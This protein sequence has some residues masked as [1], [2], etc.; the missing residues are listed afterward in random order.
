MRRRCLPR[1][2]LAVMLA[3]VCGVQV[4]AQAAPQMDPAQYLQGIAQQ[5]QQALDSGEAVQILSTSRHLAGVALQVLGAVYAA[6]EQPGQAAEAYGRSLQAEESAE[7]R[8][9]LIRNDVQAERP[10]DTARDEAQMLHAMGDTMQTRMLM[11]QAHHAAEDL[12]GTV[13]QLTL[14]VQRGDGSVGER[15]GLAAGQAGLAAA[16]LALGSA[17]WELNQFGYNAESLREFTEARRLDPASYVAN[18]DLG[19]VLSQYQRYDEA[20]GYLQAAASRDAASPDPW[21][22][23]GLNRYAQGRMGEA[24]TAL[25]KAVART[26]ADVARNHFQIMRVYAAL[27]RIETEAGHAEVAAEYGRRAEAVR[28]EMLRGDAVPVLSQ[29]TGLVANAAGGGAASQ[30][31]RLPGK[32]AVTQQQRELEQRLRQIA[33]KSL[34]DAGTA[35]ARGRDY[36]GA[37]PLFRL[38]AQTDAGLVPVMRNFGLAAFHTQHYA[39]AVTALTEAVRLDAADGTASRYLEQARSLAAAQGGSGVV[40]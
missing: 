30:A 19:A 16:H 31:E 13:A 17:Y 12:P 23:L 37:L 14:A 20:A 40:P 34:N 25:A 3:G 27:N 6:E 2:A 38:A 18:Y 33:A 1:F 4:R 36:E 10:R 24:G 11:A 15:S 22:L 26:G 32:A 21:M 28:A 9:Q 29:S 8:V 39:E 5:Q 7:A 35:L